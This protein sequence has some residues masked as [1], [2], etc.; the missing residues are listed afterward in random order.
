M[1]QR[2]GFRNLQ[3]Q[4]KQ[5][6]FDSFEDTFTQSG[7]N[8]KAEFLS[9]LIDKYL[10]PEESNAP[11]TRELEESLRIATEETEKLSARLGLYETEEMIQILNDHK[12]EK[13]TFNN[14]KGQKMTIEIRDLPDVFSAIF[15]AVKIK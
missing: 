10:A 3:I 7:A 1:G 4:M 11:D 9:W 8:T 13:L 5:N 12:G 2:Q 6:L 14:S 15:N